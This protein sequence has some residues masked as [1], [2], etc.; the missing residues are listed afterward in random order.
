MRMYANPLDFNRKKSISPASL[1][2]FLCVEHAPYG[3]S[4]DRALTIREYDW[5]VI[6]KIFV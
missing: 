6:L 4:K 1:Y 3:R 5:Q 2:F